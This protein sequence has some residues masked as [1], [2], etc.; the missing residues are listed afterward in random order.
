MRRHGHGSGQTHVSLCSPASVL[1]ARF[2]GADSCLLADANGNLDPEAPPANYGRRRSRAVLYQL[3]GH[4]KQDKIKTKLK[5]NNVS[6][7]YVHCNYFNMGCSLNRQPSLYIKLN[8]RWYLQSQ[9]I[10]IKWFLY[11]KF[12]VIIWKQTFCSIPM[13][14]LL[15]RSL[16]ASCA[17]QI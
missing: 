16:L 14:T 13:F 8:L 7:T 15:I 6:W 11:N 17:A 10:R 12:F 2:R 3:S 4:Y 9:I 5:L 1:G